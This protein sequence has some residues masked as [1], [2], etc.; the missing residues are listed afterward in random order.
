VRIEDQR[1]NNA[2][3]RAQDFILNQVGNR[4]KDACFDNAL[5]NS[6]IE[7]IRKLKRHGSLL[8]LQGNPGCGKT[9][10]AVCWMRVEM[11]HF[12]SRN[13]V[14]EGKRFYLTA[15]QFER[16]FCQPGYWEEDLKDTW[17]DLLRA[18]WVVLDDL[19]TEDQSN[20]RFKQKFHEFFDY[21][22]RNEKTLIILTNDR[23]ERY[24][25]RIISRIRDWGIEGSVWAIQEE[26]MRRRNRDSRL[27]R[28]GIL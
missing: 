4:Y 8:I 13:G 16:I 10:A 20:S 1:I 14:S 28:D 12:F 25:E 5:S 26:D 3:E 27:V 11:E 2:K 17:M 24:G 22:Y 15:S 7:Y 18:K 21:R 6:A 9:Y 23:I 19:G